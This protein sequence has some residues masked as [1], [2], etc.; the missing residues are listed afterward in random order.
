MLVSQHVNVI[1]SGENA[2][3]KH[4]IP[5]DV[6]HHSRYVNALAHRQAEIFQGSG[7]GLLILRVGE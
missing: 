4:G 3:E 2:R 1:R 5:A 7:D 6:R